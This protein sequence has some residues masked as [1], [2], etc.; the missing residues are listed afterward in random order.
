MRWAGHA[1]QMRKKKKK[2]KKKKKNAY[3]IFVGK[4]EGRKPL[5][6]SRRRWMDN[7]KMDGVV[8]TGTIWSRIGK[9][10]GLL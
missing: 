4:P 3:R 5:G 10:A 7:I 9:S 1:A 8:W 2:K 6:R